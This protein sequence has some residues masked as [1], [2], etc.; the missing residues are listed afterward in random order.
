[1]IKCLDSDITDNPDLVK[2]V[3][4]P[5]ISNVTDNLVKK[6]SHLKSNATD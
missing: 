1:M 2:K 5:H 4:L 6:F 3:D